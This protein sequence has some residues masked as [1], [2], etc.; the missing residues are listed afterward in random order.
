MTKSFKNLKQK[1]SAK[2]RQQASKKTQAMLE[3]MALQELR[4]A[5]HMSQEHLAEVLATKQANVSRMERRADMYI[6][7]LRSYIEAMGGKL[8]IVAHF[9]EGDVTINQFEDIK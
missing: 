8:H 9:P 4:Q 2:A 6:S 5:R 3:E 1:M 7:T